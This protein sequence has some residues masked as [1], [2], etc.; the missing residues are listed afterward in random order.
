MTEFEPLLQKKNNTPN[1]FLSTYTEQSSLAFFMTEDYQKSFA[2]EDIFKSCFAWLKNQDTSPVYIYFLGLEQ[3]TVSSS[4]DFIVRAYSNFSYEF[5]SLKQ[6]NENEKIEKEIFFV[7]E[8]KA[9]YKQ[10]LTEAVTITN[11]VNLAKDLGNLPSNICTPSY[12]ANFAKEKAQKLKV[13]C[14]IYD[15]EKINQLGMHSFLSVAKGSVEEPYFIELKYNGKNEKGTDPIVL[16]GKG[17]TFDSGGIS[18]K[19]PKN[20][21]EMKYDMC[22]AANVLLTFFT[23]VELKLPIN[24]VTLVPTCEN[25]PS[26]RS[27]KPGDIVQSLKGLSIEILNTDA[28]GRLIL[29][30]ALTY[31]EKF[32]PQAVIDVATLTGACVVALGHNISGIL[33]THQELVDELL[34]ASHNTRDKTWQLPLWEEHQQELK[35]NF[36]ALAHVGSSGYA[37]TITAAAFLSRFIDEKYQWAHIDIA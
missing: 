2:S 19:P 11:N 18:L 20:M 3:E 13:Q 4:I 10:K 17:I 6:K 24:L 23:A 16:I 32:Q 1:S 33:G 27:M 14:E 29:C 5:K 30:D 35:S 7:V 26:D 9:H 28:E 21:D 12:L 25:M 37:G 22:G 36:A 31:A 15:R 8:N 34:T